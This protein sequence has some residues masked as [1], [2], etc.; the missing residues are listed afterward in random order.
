MSYTQQTKTPLAPATQAL[1]ELLRSAKLQ[2]PTGPTI[3]GQAAMAAQSAPPP[4][5]P[6]AGPEQQGIAAILDQAKDAGPTIAQNQQDAQAQKTAQMAAQ[7][8]KQSAQP[9]A[10]AQGYAEGGIA[11]LPIEV[12]DFSEGGVL[13]YAD[14]GIAEPT[15]ASAADWVSRLAPK[16]DAELEAEAKRLYEEQKALR[17]GRPDTAA[18]RTLSMQDA[19]NKEVAYRPTEQNIASLLGGAKGLG[20]FAQAA[21]QTKA[22]FAKRDAA[23]KEG[24][25]AQRDL[26]YA[27]KI[28]DNEAIQKA[29]DARRAAKQKY[30]ELSTAITGDTLKSQASIFNTKTDAASQAAN[31]AT[32]ERIARIGAATR[33][34]AAPAK[35]W[36]KMRDDVRADVKNFLDTNYKAKQAMGSDPAKYLELTKKFMKDAVTKAKAMGENVPPEALAFLSD[37]GAG[38]V[39]DSKVIDSSSIKPSK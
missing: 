37:S 10:Q 15:A 30:D 28:G 4:A 12:G 5:P 25:Q 23:Y 16:Q 39:S 11:N 21:I 35:G 1:L 6:V 20:G 31:R 38:G 29:L 8:V 9:P 13:G 22:A 18:Q 17:A 24:E 34:T 27:Q 14:G 32:Q 33:E 3:A 19:Y 7:M 2:T 26:E 36:D